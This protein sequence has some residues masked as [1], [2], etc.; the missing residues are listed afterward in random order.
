MLSFYVVPDWLAA[1]E[2]CKEILSYGGM[3]HTMSIHSADEKVILEFG[4]RKPAFR[5]VV[6]TPT[7][8]GSI[9]MTTGLDPSMTLGVRRL[10]REHHV[11]QHHTASP[12][13]HQAPG[14]RGATGQ[15]VCTP[16]T[17]RARVTTL[18]E[19]PAKRVSGGVDPE[20]LARRIET[21]LTSRG[22][23]PSSPASPASP[24]NDNTS[25][26]RQPDAALADT[27]RR[28]P[29]G[30]PPAPPPTP[31]ETP[32]EFVCEDDVRQAVQA[33]RHIVVNDR[34]IITPAARDLDRQHRIFVQADLP[35]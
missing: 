11:R 20:V 21:F 33:D 35:R 34:T 6:N 2:R 1:C 26:R 15:V 7:T 14:L 32:V 29:A 30:V 31:V 8:F 27:A 17:D 19:A 18:P 16:A 24:E 9:G 22:I 5:I 10:R 28:T 3:G 4:L 13:E 25:T 12:A 23:A